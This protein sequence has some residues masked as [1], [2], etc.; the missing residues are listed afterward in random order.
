MN[1]NNIQPGDQLFF[2]TRDSQDSRRNG[3]R[4]VTKVGRDWIYFEGSAPRARIESLIADGGV[5]SSP[6]RY[7]LTQEEYED[8]RKLYLAWHAFRTDIA[9]I[10]KLPE[11]LTIEAIQDARKRLG[12]LKKE[13][14]K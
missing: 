8:E 7:W 6:G 12:V 1:P 9:T 11:D 4:T 5:Y 10:Y 13:V 3:Y 2:S 14:L